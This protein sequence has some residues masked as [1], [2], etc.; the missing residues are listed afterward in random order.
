MLSVPGGLK[1][2]VL[3]VPSSG[4]TA[5]GHPARPPRDCSQAEAIRRTPG[6]AS[7]PICRCPCWTTG[8]S[9][10]RKPCEAAC[11]RQPS[12]TETTAAFALP[13]LRARIHGQH[14]PQDPASSP[15]RCFR[16]RGRCRVGV[17]GRFG[18]HFASLH[19]NQKSG[20]PRLAPPPA[21]VAFDGAGE[22][23]CRHEK[24]QCPT[25]C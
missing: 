22:P 9:A 24:T 5:F 6:P 21:S 8:L 7:G 10:R 2:G 3:T 1:K 14:T 17:C 16:A 12:A 4:C 19:F 18:H 23:D 13:S 11:R 25:K 20:N 15:A